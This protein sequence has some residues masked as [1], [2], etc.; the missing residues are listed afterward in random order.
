MDEAFKRWLCL[1]C[2]FLYDEALG[3]PEHGLAP[4]TRWADIPDDWRCPDCGTPKRL[5]EM[6]ELPYAVGQPVPRTSAGGSAP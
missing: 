2:G 4:G 1:G 5:F 6:V 3:A